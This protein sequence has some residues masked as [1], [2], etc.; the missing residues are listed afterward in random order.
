MHTRSAVR[1]RIAWTERRSGPRARQ[2]KSTRIWIKSLRATSSCTASPWIGRSII[3]S[4]RPSRRRADFG[5]RTQRHWAWLPTPL[6]S[7]KPGRHGV[8]PVGRRPQAAQ[9]QVRRVQVEQPAGRPDVRRPLAGFD[10]GD[11]RDHAQRRLHRLLAVQAD[12]QLEGRRFLSLNQSKSRRASGR[13]AAGG[14]AG[15]RGRGRCSASP[16]RS[17][18]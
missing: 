17:S 8:G 18:R 10:D 14:T 12:R 16:T 7:S 1:G 15:R 5:S 6:T 3:G 11:R 9:H 13:R 4:P 2:L